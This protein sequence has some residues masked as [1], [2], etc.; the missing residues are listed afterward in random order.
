MNRPR[1]VRAPKIAR[2][3]RCFGHAERTRAGG[4]V[5]PRCGLR[6]REGVTVA[7]SSDPRQLD[8][9]PAD[10]LDMTLSLF[11]QA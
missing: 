2:C 5:C 8:A 3:S 9:L 10:Q 7:D 6:S 11:G 4:Y 1:Q